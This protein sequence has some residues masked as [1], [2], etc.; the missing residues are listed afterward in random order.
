MKKW[1]PVLAFAAVV[2]TVI[3]L[4]VWW[5]MFRFRECRGVGHSLLYCVLMAG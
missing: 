3:G 1:Y 2:L 4:G 5:Q